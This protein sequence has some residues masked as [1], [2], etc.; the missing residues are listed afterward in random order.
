[1]SS[2]V[3][4][5]LP[6]LP[7][8]SFE[9]TPA[10]PQPHTIEHKWTMGITYMLAMGVCGTILVAIGSSLDDFAENC[11]TTSTDVASVF[12]ARGIGAILG[13]IASAKLYMWYQGNFIM[14]F[15][16]GSIA[17]L[18]VCLPFN[19]STIGLH[20]L[21]FLLG[22]CTA[23]TDTG[24]QIMTRKI[25]GKTAGPWLGANTVAFGIAGAIVPLIDRKSTRLNSSHVSESRMPSSA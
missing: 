8:N 20:I 4:S 18:L 1:M 15:S 2:E 9:A 25:H 23:I 3:V 13:A 11:G 24:C 10:A 7:E 16:L 19:T 12:I 5:K 6:K 17:F 14:S 21:F 22:I